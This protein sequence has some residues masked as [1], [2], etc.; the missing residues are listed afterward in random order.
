ME[1]AT[2]TGLP[3]VLGPESKAEK[4]SG[5]DS[6]A[7]LDLSTATRRIIAERKAKAAPERSKT[8]W[9]EVLDLLVPYRDI[10]LIL[11]FGCVV[12]GVATWTMPGALILLGLGLMTVSRFLAQ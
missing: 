12:A 7:G 4:S 11:G 9:Y 5:E 8:R 2:E 1:K 10:P 6:Y 3:K